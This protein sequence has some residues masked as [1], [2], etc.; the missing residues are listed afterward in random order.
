M[1]GRLV[2]QERPGNEAESVKNL[3][4]KHD[5]GGPRDEQPL[6]WLEWL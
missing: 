5:G 4:A 6:L 1:N 2:R 3:R